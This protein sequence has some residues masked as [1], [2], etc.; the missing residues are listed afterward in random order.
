[1]DPLS[2]LTFFFIFFICMFIFIIVHWVYTKH[3]APCKKEAPYDPL[4]Y[5]SG[6]PNLLKQIYEPIKNFFISIIPGI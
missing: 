5:I 6:D 2:V 1:M 4:C 3:I